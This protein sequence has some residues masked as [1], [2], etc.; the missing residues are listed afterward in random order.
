MRIIK[1]CI[2]VMVCM[3]I[4]T[5]VN[6]QEKDTTQKK[7]WPFGPVVPAQISFAPG[8]GTNGRQVL[9]IRGVSFNVLGGK[10]NS[11]TGFEFAGFFNIDQKNVAYTQVAGLFNKVCGKVTGAQVAGLFNTVGDSVIGAQ[12]GGLFNTVNKKVRGAQ[13]GGLFNMVGDSVIGIQVA[14]LYNNVAKSVIGAQVGGLTNIVNGDVAGFQV[15]GLV[16]KV[17]GKVTGMTVAGL[18]NGTKEVEGL[19]VA[20]LVNHTKKLKGVQIGLINIADTSEGCSIGLINIAKNGFYQFS[21]YANETNSVNVAFR[22][23][24]K[25][26]Y[27]ILLGGANP[28]DNKK[29]YTFGAGFGGAVKLARNISIN[30]EITSQY[31]YTGDWQY[32]NLLQKL[33]AN[34]NFTVAKGLTF[35]AGP[36]FSVYYTDQHVDVKDY[37]Q[38]MP[39]Y[40]VM[41]WWDNT[42]AWFGWTV[43][44]SF[45]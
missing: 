25:N 13:V 4:L 10:N 37:K 15:G 29:L 32:T 42:Y 27:G 28:S 44:V 31:M 26:F 36:S 1:Q 11:V 14:G 20:G 33:S 17:H 6:A 3:N 21:L 39:S 9:D 12:V 30:P 23:G 22:S 2:A 40:G 35:Y 41:H 16:N 7:P 5:L 43:G 38:P 19:Q 24:T 34:F 45:F 8:V 18:F